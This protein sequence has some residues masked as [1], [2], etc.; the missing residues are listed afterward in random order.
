[1]FVITNLGPFGLS[2]LVDLYESV[3]LI[4]S[5]PGIAAVLPY[6]KKLFNGHN[7]STNGTRRVHLVWQ[8]RSFGMYSHVIC[9]TY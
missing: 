2:K 3:L 9:A 1:M 4:A 7:T 5:G 6:I 8:L